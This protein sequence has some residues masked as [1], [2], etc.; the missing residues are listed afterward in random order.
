MSGS[1]NR[2]LTAAECQR[3]DQ[4]LAEGLSHNKVAKEMGRSQST[5]SAYAKRSGQT[6]IIHRTPNEAIARRVE[7]SLESRLDATSEL[8]AKVMELARVAKSGREMKDLATA[9][10][11]L[12]DKVLLL[13]G[14]PTSR[15][16]F[17]ST[18]ATATLNLQEEFSKLDRALAEEMDSNVIEQQEYRAGRNDDSLGPL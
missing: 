17:N 5:V 7:L 3:I 12:T 1:N 16:E 18:R 8:K 4:L 9:W 2:L 10:G 11:I 15:S 14:L 13:Q 6:P